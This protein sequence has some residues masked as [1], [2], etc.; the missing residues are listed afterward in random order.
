MHCINCASAVEKRLRAVPQV[1]SARVHY[2]PAAPSSRMAKIVDIAALQSAL[3]PE[4][5]SLTPG[6][7]EA[8]PPRA[9]YLQGLC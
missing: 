4:G 2:P 8:A 5:Y 9:E 7:D 3:A 6:V 1:E